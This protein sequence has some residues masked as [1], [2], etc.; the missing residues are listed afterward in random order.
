MSIRNYNAFLKAARKASKRTGGLSLPAARKVYKTMAARL[1]R[2]LK[3]T[4]VRKHPRIF[5]ES[6]RT[7]KRAA[8]S[9]TPKVRKPGLEKPAAGKRTIS[10]PSQPATKRV[11]SKPAKRVPVR[12]PEQV[13]ES[14]KDF[15][16]LFDLML[17]EDLEYASSTEYG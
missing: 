3:G 5:G 8:P 12:K 4:D 1:G 2:P 9:G 11:P 6:E 14:I 15:D 17:Q 13:I 10:K 7:R 16:K